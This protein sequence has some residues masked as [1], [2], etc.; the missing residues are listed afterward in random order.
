MAKI[1]ELCDENA[2]VALQSI[3]KVSGYGYVGKCLY[4]YR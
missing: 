4:L 2:K 3:K 1:Y